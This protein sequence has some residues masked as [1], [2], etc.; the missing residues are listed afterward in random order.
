MTSEACCA[1]GRSNTIIGDH[2]N[3]PSPF[4]VSVFWWLPMGR[5]EGYYAFVC[6]PEAATY[7]P[8]P[9]PAPRLCPTLS[10]HI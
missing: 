4:A 5:R 3:I 7:S 9:T 8:E 10:G 6:S 1:L 2:S